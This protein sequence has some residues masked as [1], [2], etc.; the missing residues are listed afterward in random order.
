VIQ[1]NCKYCQSNNVVKYGKYNGVQ[2]YFCYDCDRK[3]TEIDA[4]FK[5]QTPVNQIAAA[6]SM[7]YEGLSQNETQRMLKQIYKNDVSDFAIYNWIERFTKDAVNVT[8][9]YRPNVGYVWMADETVIKV[10]GKKY[11]LL[12]VIDV[13]TRF[14]IASR[15]SPTRRVEDVQEVLKEAYVR[16]GR[17]PK[18]ILTD[19]LEAY[20]QGVSFTFG[21]QSKHVQV[22]K[23]ADNPNNNII[24]RMQGTIKAR[25]KIMRDLKS[26]H[27]AQLI[28][29]G[30]LVNYNYFRPHETLGTTPAKKAQIAFP[31]EDWEALIKHS[32]EPL[33]SEPHYEEIEPLP[34]IMPN[35]YEQMRIDKMLH[36]RRALETK[37]TGILYVPKNKGGGRRKRP[38]F[39]TM[40]SL[41]SYR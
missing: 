6:L 27:T 3:F 1:M 15:L 30:F 11:W 21:N 2:R 32:Q 8:N 23:Y 18:V 40:P 36:K 26:L 9:H 34:Y 16:T 7:Y 29:D 28:L 31:Y 25:T 37:R 12:D 19:H 17:I 41:R 33:P 24:E 35:A 20:I 13:K 38:Q 4:L 14:L 10:G 39:Q 22:K 5:M